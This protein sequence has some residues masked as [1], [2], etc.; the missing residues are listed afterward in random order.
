MAYTEYTTHSVYA[1]NIKCL[2][3][4][5]PASFHTWMC[6]G[7]CTRIYMCAWQIGT[8]KL[9]RYLWWNVFWLLVF[10]PFLSQRQGIILLRAGDVRWHYVPLLLL[11]GHICECSSRVARK[12]SPVN[13]AASPQN[14]RICSVIILNLKCLLYGWRSISLMVGRLVIFIGSSGGGGRVWVWVCVCDWV[15]V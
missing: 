5:S 1:P 14:E 9:N 11:P 3:L 8:R 10:G 13:Q 12:K 2:K 15:D 6:T 7:T 4:R